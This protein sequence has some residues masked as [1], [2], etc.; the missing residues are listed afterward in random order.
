MGY[1]IFCLIFL[2]LAD[3]GLFPKNKEM[4]KK[5]IEH[6][7]LKTEKKGLH[8]FVNELHFQQI[9]GEKILSYIRIMLESLL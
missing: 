7:A 1:L 4:E 5:K 2:L 3:V 9:S 8:K 6:K